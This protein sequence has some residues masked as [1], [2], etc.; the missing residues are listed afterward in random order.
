MLEPINERSKIIKKDF[1]AQKI[2]SILPTSKDAFE[3]LGESYA[4]YLHEYF[5][6]KVLEHLRHEVSGSAEM[7]VASTNAELDAVASRKAQLKVRASLVEANFP[8]N[9]LLNADVIA[10]NANKNALSLNSS[11]RYRNI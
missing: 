5:Y 10:A 1:L 8:D 9:L 3:R 11:T 7:S 2:I 6:E 4:Y